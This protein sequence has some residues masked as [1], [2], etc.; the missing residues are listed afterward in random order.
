M[1]RKR[2]VD[3][4]AVV[5]FA[6]AHPELRQVDIAMHFGA[7]KTS[8]WRILQG[9]HPHHQPGK[10]CTGSETH[11]HHEAVVE[12]A[13][14]HPEL[15]QVDIAMHF[16]ASKT[17]VWRILQGSGITS[18]DRQGQHH[19]KGGRNPKK[20]GSQTDLVHDW[21]TILHREG[22]GMNRGSSINGK[23]ITYGYDY[24]FKVH[25]PYDYDDLFR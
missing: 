3:H 2:I 24:T 21:E 18:A 23:S 10:V 4:E 12:F 11:L 7:S 20:R 13:K 25:D 9:C 17:S 1:A 14:A 6:K 5:E 15:R 16:G 22:L 8:V 19:H